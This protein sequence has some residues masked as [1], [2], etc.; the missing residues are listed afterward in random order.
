[1]QI[2]WR[3]TATAKQWLNTNCSIVQVNSSSTSYGIIGLRPSVYDGVCLYQ[4]F[5]SSNV[6]NPSSGYCQN[7]KTLP[8]ASCPAGAESFDYR[9][10]TR[11]CQFLEG[12]YGMAYF[13]SDCTQCAELN[14]VTCL[15]NSTLPV[16]SA[17]FCRDQTDPG[18]A[19]PCIPSSACPNSTSSEVWS[20]TCAV[21]YTGNLCG[22][23][24]QG[25]WRYFPYCMKSPEFKAVVPLMQTVLFFVSW[26]SLVPRF[27]ILRTL[28]R[29]PE[30]SFKSS[31][32]VCLPSSN[33]EVP[34]TFAKL[35]A[36]F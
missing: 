29:W 1:L 5:T 36:C 20:T 19:I 13:G 11:Y 31:S 9:N 27:C 12:S 22:T 2:C 18:I 16:I 17:G 4:R 23:C 30:R 24:D 3:E 7:V 6:M 34:Y 33:L 14:G 15:Q 21:G 35:L 8:G 26:A 28:H 10:S 32:Y 25:Y